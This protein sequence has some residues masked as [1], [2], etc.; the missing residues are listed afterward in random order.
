[1]PTRMEQAKFEPFL[2]KKKIVSLV[3]VSVAGRNNFASYRISSSRR[4][5][6]LT[7]GNVLHPLSRV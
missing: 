6:I 3:S 2:L 4:S 1:M 7:S 5:V